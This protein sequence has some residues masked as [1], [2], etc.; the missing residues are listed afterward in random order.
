MP[1]GCALVPVRTTM[2]F[3]MIEICVGV[4]RTL[5]LLSQNCATKTKARSFKSGKR[6]DLRADN[7][8][9][10]GSSIAVC[11]AYMTLLSGKLTEYGVRH[12]LLLVHSILTAVQS[13]EVH[14]LWS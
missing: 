4:K 12:G 5:Q 8:N 14:L 11:V 6:Y 1:Y 3:L 10:G 2:L 7:G 9:Q 13:I